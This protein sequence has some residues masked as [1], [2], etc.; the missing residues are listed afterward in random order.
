LID[1]VCS[2]KKTKT[3]KQKQKTK[4][5]QKNWGKQSLAMWANGI[6]IRPQQISVVLASGYP[7]CSLPL[8]SDAFFHF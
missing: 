7:Q 5:K 4:T 1:A 6:F 2:Q 3:K 8:H